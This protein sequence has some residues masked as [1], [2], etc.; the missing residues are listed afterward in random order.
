MKKFFF[1]NYKGSITIEASYIMPIL[2]GITVL[3]IFL[4]LTLHD[5]T[6]SNSTQYYFL[7]RQSTSL[8]NKVYT[9]ISGYNKRDIC[10][11]ISDLSI[12]TKEN[13][14]T[15]CLAGNVLYLQSSSQKNNAIYFSNFEKCDTIRKETALILQH[16]KK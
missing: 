14:L 8:E 2:L 1:K 6:V 10:N 5:Y 7:I 4:L 15:C 9:P 3:L 13:P 11:T 12:I 16:L